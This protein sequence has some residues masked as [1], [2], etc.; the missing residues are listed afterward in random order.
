MLLS[1]VKKLDLASLQEEAFEDF[2]RKIPPRLFPQ[3]TDLRLTE[4][5]NHDLVASIL[6]SSTE[7]HSLYLDNLQVEGRIP[8]GSPMPEEL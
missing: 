8:D 3:L 4:W 1:N 2:A 7:L 5:M 6:S